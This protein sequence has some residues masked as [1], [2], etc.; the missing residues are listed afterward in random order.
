MN[1][2]LFTNFNTLNTYIKF[3]NI[4]MTQ[5]IT[6]FGYL[7]CLENGPTSVDHCFFLGVTPQIYPLNT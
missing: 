4:F 1:D 6:H 2:I 7:A 3:C 5:N